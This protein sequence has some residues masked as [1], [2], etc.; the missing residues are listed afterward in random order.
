MLHPTDPFQ[1]SDPLHGWGEEAALS[2]SHYGIV[3]KPQVVMQSNKFVD[4]CLIVAASDV[5]LQ[6]F[7]ILDVHNQDDPITGH[8]MS[9]YET[10]TY[11]MWPN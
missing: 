4:A 9:R 10:R 8:I 11:L 1:P 7:H 5:S 3:I 2:R 6:N